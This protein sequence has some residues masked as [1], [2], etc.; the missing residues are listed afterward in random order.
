[1]AEEAAVLSLAVLSSVH[2]SFLSCGRSASAIAD[3]TPLMT[4]KRVYSSGEAIWC[5]S[6]MISPGG[7]REGGG[8]GEGG[9]VRGDDRV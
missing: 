1:M 7:G 8:G 3:A 4:E 2:C 9:G 6:A 5:R